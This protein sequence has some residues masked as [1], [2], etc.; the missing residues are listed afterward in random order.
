MLG[1]RSF[2][3]S[4]KILFSYKGKLNRK[5]FRAATI[6][7][8]VVSFLISIINSSIF[9][10]FSYLGLLKEGT[11]TALMIFLI[12]A[13][14]FWGFGILVLYSIVCIAIKRLRDLNKSGWHILHLFA[15]F[16]ISILVGVSM[17]FIKSKLMSIVALVTPLFQ[18]YS[19]GFWI[20]LLFAKNKSEA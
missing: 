13:P 19:L 6:F 15:P 7:W 14:V 12:F 16:L 10:I 1:K 8:I 5:D 11:T 2:S 20:Y 9:S 3:E 4:K 18:F 17:F